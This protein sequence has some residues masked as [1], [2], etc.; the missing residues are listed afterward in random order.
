MRVPTTGVTVITTLLVWVVAAAPSDEGLHLRDHGRFAKGELLCRPTDIWQ[1]ADQQPTVVWITVQSA[2][3]VTRWI[4]E[5][6]FRVKLEP[7]DEA[8]IETVGD[9]AQVVLDKLDT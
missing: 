3:P 9:L 5:N 8:R 1:S 6:H 2:S 4:V 7:A